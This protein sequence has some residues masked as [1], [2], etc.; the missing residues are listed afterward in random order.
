MVRTPDNGH[1]KTKQQTHP[2][3]VPLLIYN[4]GNIVVV[5][6]D[7]TTSYYSYWYLV[8]EAPVKWKGD[9]KLKNIN[10]KS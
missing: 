6:C 10:F 5:W 3:F 4:N 8:L 1:L 7:S 9:K 2:A